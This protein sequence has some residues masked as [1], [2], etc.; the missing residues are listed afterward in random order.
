MNLEMKTVEIRVRLLGFLARL[1]GSDEI[2]LRFDENP[3]LG[4]LLGK[5]ARRR[6]R[7]RKALFDEDGDLSWNI[8]LL[9]NRRDVS[10]LDGLDTRLEDGDEVVLAPI[11]HGG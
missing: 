5:L 7:F 11:S 4:E 6:R 9:V 10:V 3:R 8:L 1:Y 2:T